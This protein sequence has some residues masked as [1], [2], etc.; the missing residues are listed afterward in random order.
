MLALTRYPAPSWFCPLLAAQSQK[1]TSLAE[2]Q[3]PHLYPG[4]GIS[5]LDIQ[6]E[7]L[8]P[9]WR[10]AWWPLVGLPSASEGKT[11]LSEAPTPTPSAP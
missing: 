5:I 10:A 6:H 9:P 1:G 8:T 4:I 2:T 3:S 11:T 7:T